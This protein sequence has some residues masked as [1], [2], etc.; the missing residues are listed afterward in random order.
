MSAGYRHHLARVANSLLGYASR[1]WGQAEKAKCPHDAAYFE[2]VGARYFAQSCDLIEWADALALDPQA[3]PRSAMAQ[4]FAQH[5]PQ[6][7]TVRMKT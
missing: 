1:M 6:P 7:K 2:R 5:F 3:P 4:A